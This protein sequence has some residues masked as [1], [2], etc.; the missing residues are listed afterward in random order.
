MDDGLKVPSGSR[1]PAEVPPPATGQVIAGGTPVNEVNEKVKNLGK[2]VSKVGKVPTQ[3]NLKTHKWSVLK[4]M[5]DFFRNLAQKISGFFQRLFG[6]SSSAQPTPI[7]PPVITVTPPDTATPTPPVAKKELEPTISSPSVSSPKPVAPEPVSGSNIDDEI[8]QAGAQFA[9][10]AAEYDDLKAGI[11]QLFKDEKGKIK[12]SF[13][14]LDLVLLKGNVER[15][16]EYEQQLT[17]LSKY[18]DHL[19]GF[20]DLRN[21]FAKLQE[22]IYKLVAKPNDEKLKNVFREFSRIDTTL[23]AKGKEK[24]LK[25]LLKS[26]VEYAGLLGGF[27]IRL[28][29]KDFMSRGVRFPSF[30]LGSWPSV[31][32]D[33]EGEWEEIPPEVL[34]GGHSKVELP[35]RDV[36]ICASPNIGN[37]CYINSSLQS[38]R[39]F[40]P[41]RERVNAELTRGVTKN[42]DGKPILEPEEKFRHRKNVQ[43]KLA[44]LL[45]ALD[46]YESFDE[47]GKKQA[48]FRDAL[49]AS[50]LIDDLNME[51]ILEQQDAGIFIE[52]LLKEVLDFYPLLIRQTIV[53]DERPKE[54]EKLESDIVESPVLKMTL[55]PNITNVQDLLIANLAP[56]TVTK[57]LMNY[58]TFVEE[59]VQAKKRQKILGKPQPV[60]TLRFNRTIFNKAGNRVDRTPL[61]WP[62]GDIIDLSRAY[63]GKPDARYELC[64]FVC[65]RGDSANG[66][67]YY[68][69]VKQGND[70]YKCD[71]LRKPSI[72]KASLAEVNVAKQQA[73]V[74]FLDRIPPPPNEP[75]PD[76]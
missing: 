64:S 67:H 25:I 30:Q 43:E 54:Y 50:G 21:N 11:G 4:A 22:D 32:W 52:T 19:E 38:L 46:N 75:P 68:N 34:A 40:A 5:G 23:F 47:I 51:N 56:E 20:K 57:N 41:F 33:D 70:W 58:S 61:D 60:L 69:Y 3:S 37:S 17:S 24:Q 8:E 45:K 31:D 35:S 15:L 10:I 44:S 2:S 71:D 7:K 18:S 12:S 9:K 29:E 62:Q 55:S 66:G 6:K 72:I 16:T 28:N 53:A 1:I 14:E 65:H 39:F 26:I 13:E 74:A 59:P 73:I 63:R 36:P 76:E 27:G 48:A 42:A 49:A